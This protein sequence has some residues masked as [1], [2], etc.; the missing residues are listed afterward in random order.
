MGDPI[1]L[2]A[3]IIH[4]AASVNVGLVASIQVAKEE[5]KV[6]IM[7]SIDLSREVDLSTLLP[8]GDD[9]DGGV[10][11]K[12]ATDHMVHASHGVSAQTGS[13]GGAEEVLG[14]LEYTPTGG[15]EV[16]L[17]GGDGA[18]VETVGAVVGDNIGEVQVG[19]ALDGMI[20]RTLTRGA[21][22]TMRMRDGKQ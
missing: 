18:S 6:T 11:H 14:G 5:L 9:G 21:H 2:D 19:A 15:R 20:R 8:V 12:V 13:V 10:G 16:G 4:K 7:I 3:L 1:E 22:H 17:D